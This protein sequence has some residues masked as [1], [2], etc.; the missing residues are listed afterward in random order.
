MDQTLEQRLIAAK[1]IAAGASTKRIQLE[2]KLEAAQ[3]R[4]KELLEKCEQLNIK[5]QDLQKR[6]SE[7]D[8]SIQEGLDQLD[9]FLPQNK[10]SDDLPYG[11]I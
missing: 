10:S 8:V 11:S 7:L 9:M 2:T 4:K 6:I 3:L 1:Q 5:P